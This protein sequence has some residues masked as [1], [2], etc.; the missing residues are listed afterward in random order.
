MSAPIVDGSELEFGDVVQIAVQRSDGRWWRRF[1]IVMRVH[2]GRIDTLNLKMRP[3]LEPFVRG[4]DW[5]MDMDITRTFWG[6]P[7]IITKLPEPWPQGVTAM[8]TKLMA[9]GIIKLEDE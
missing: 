4:T 2:K 9:Q 6:E 3:N 8:Y 7:Q 5:S 1:A